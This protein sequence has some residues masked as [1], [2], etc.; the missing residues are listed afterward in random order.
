MKLS[1][2][3]L[4]AACA[5][6]WGGSV[7]LV[8]LANLACGTYGLAFLDMI[9]SIYPGTYLMEVKPA[10]RLP[11]VTEPVTVVGYDVFL[12]TNA[13]AKDEDVTAILTALYDSLEGLKK[14][15]PPIRAAT[16]EAMANTSNTAPYHP[17]AVAFFK[18]KGLWSEANDAKDAA[19]Q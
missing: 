1:I 5:I 14:D 19:L 3:G 2:K 11:E 13:E 10:K 15:Y 7:F 17:A 6:V 4:A 12:V 8:A 16:Q 9:D 18:E